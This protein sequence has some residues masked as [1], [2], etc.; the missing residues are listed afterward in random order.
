MP[1]SRDRQDEGKPADRKLILE[2]NSGCGN[3]PFR[4]RR[5]RRGR[6]R[7]FFSTRGRGGIGGGPHTTREERTPTEARG[8]IEVLTF[9]VTNVVLRAPPPT[10]ARHY[11]F[12]YATFNYGRETAKLIARRVIA[13]RDRDSRCYLHA[14]SFQTRS[15]TRKNPHRDKSGPRAPSA[16]ASDGPVP[17]HLADP[18]FDPRFAPSPSS[19]LR[20][21]LYC[22]RP[23]GSYVAIALSLELLTLNPLLHI[24]RVEFNLVARIVFSPGDSI[25]A[26]NGR[27]F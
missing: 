4:R 15:R 22:R 24:A 14:N 12:I 26:V 3:I 11:L 5:R 19:A 6:G 17:S 18:R 27:D 8:L 10:G 23:V 16:R 20:V 1:G 9:K 2:K 25:P 21:I 13:A 7:G